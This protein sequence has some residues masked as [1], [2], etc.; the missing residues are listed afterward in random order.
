MKYLYVLLCMFTLTAFG[1]M[2]ENYMECRNRYGA[3]SGWP[4]S[5]NALP[6]QEA[7]FETPNWIISIKFYKRKAIQIAYYHRKGFPIDMNLQKE[8]LR[9]NRERYSGKCEGHMYLH[10]GRWFF[11]VNN[12]ESCLRAIAAEVEEEL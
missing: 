10:E 6:T 3:G 7:V 11:I 2:G 8:I 9:V 5:A 4:W 12:R 1:R